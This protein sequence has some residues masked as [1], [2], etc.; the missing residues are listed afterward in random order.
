ML[1]LQMRYVHHP[2]AV[3]QQVFQEA[4]LH[5]PIHGA[6]D[7][8]LR[9]QPALWQAIIHASSPMRA[10]AQAHKSFPSRHHLEVYPPPCSRQMFY[11]MAEVQDL[12]LLLLQVEQRLIPI[13]G[14]MAKPLLQQPD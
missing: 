10:D 2:M 4:L 1:R 3:R 9:R 5:L 6:T 14:A 13:H 7:K 12:L 8:P 11:V